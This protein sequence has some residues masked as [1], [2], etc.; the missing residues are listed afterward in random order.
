MDLGRVRARLLGGG[1]SSL[2]AGPE[3]P[4]AAQAPG[5]GDSGARML[6]LGPLCVISVRTRGS[7]VSQ[8]RYPRKTLTFT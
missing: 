1:G 2:L 8:S 7:C 4:L 3:L 6:A 5:G